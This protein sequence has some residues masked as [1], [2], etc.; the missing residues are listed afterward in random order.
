M[1]HQDAIRSQTADRYLLGDL[2]GAERDEFESHFFECEEC[3]DAVRTGVLF[4]DNAAAEFPALT[5]RVPS[6]AAKPGN[7]WKDWFRFD[8]RQP[9]FVLPLLA[10]IAVSGL[11][12][13]DHARLRSELS[14]ATEPQS[15]AEVQLDR[16][17]GA[18]VAVTREGRYFAVSFY[19]NHDTLPEYSIEISGNGV[20][21]ATVRAQT[22]H[23]GRYYILLPSSRYT[24]GNYEIAVKSGPG[25]DGRI[26]QQFPLSIE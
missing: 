15:F 2:A 7:S 24:A 3:A 20:S 26:I 25:S 1:E 6:L 18:A 4:I 11:W 10:L 19:I 23:D 21:P 14:S 13:T 9:A 22:Q 16:T 8:W 5:T 17:R 12:V